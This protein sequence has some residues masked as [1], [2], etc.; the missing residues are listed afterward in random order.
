MKT[1]RIQKLREQRAEIIEKMGEMT[2]TLE[3]ENRAFT[4]EEQADFDAREKTVQNIDATIAS[5]ERALK[6]EC[7]ETDASQGEQ[8]AEADR[9]ELETHAFE[10]YL[11]GEEM[12]MQLR[13]DVNWQTSSNGAVIPSTIANKIIDK[14]VD[15]CPVYQMATRYDVG[16]TLS[17]PYYD[18]TSGTIT[19]DYASEFSALSSTAGKFSS[20][21]LT[22]YLA[23]CLSK[24]P[25]TLI[26]NSQFDI[27]NFV[28]NKMAEKISIWIE[29]QL[30]NGTT[31]KIEGLTGVTEKITTAAATKITADE[32]IDLQEALPDAYQGNAIFIMNR[33]TR[34]AI[35][36]LKDNDDNYLLNRDMSAK[37]GYTLLGK[38]VYCS[39]NMPT[40]AGGKT[41]I[42]YGDLSGLAV[43]VAENP[44]IDIMREKFM[45]E[46]AVGVVA[47]LEMDAKV[48]NA[49]KIAALVMKAS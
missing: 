21:Q 10:M 40:M 5:L 49:Q 24:I 3:V 30:L 22:G 37:W 12:D 7:T 8:R 35:R 31:G 48:E 42:Y 19:M 17:I 14:V 45:D 32:L 20:I 2:D 34:T 16:G 4:E 46:H 23:G 9:E 36:K 13:A 47:W 15:I 6:L 1:N 38:D 18:E 43:K 11:R 39:D 25:R 29:G 27:V 41:A 28:I 44:Q 33:A 26:N